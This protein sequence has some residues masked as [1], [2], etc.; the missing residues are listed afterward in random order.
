M[1]EFEARAQEALERSYKEFTLYV[2]KNKSKLDSPQQ[3]LTGM[4]YYITL[5]AYNK[6]YRISKENNAITPHDPEIYFKTLDIFTIPNGTFTKEGVCIN[7]YTLNANDYKLG[8]Q[9]KVEMDKSLDDELDI[10]FV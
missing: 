3:E 9:A 5:Y 10:I 6:A 4:T 2:T 8:I 7:I 1:E